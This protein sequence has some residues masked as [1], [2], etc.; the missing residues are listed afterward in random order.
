MSIFK[1]YIYLYRDFFERSISPLSLIE[2]D[3]SIAFNKSNFISIYFLYNVKEINHFALLAFQILVLDKTKL[4]I[5]K[6]I[7]IL[8]FFKIDELS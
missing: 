6:I 8:Y 5:D 2:Y 3:N 4:K 1:D 7:F